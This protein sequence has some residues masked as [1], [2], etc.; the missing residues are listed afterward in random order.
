MLQTYRVRLTRSQFNGTLHGWVFP[1]DSR[2]GT[3]SGGKHGDMH[4]RS[5]YVRSQGLYKRVC[6]GLK[7]WNGVQDSPTNVSGRLIMW[8]VFG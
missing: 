7:E 4:V 1:P 6:F 8:R 3:G 5:P 2:N